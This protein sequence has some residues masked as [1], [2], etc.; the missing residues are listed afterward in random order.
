[1]LLFRLPAFI[2]YPISFM[3]HLYE[4][5]SSFEKQSY[6]EYTKTF[7]EYRKYTHPYDYMDRIVVN[8][9]VSNNSYSIWEVICHF[10]VIDDTISNIHMIDTTDE[11][12]SMIQNKYKKS[13]ISPLM[14]YDMN[15]FTDMYL[16]YIERSSNRFMDWYSYR[17]DTSDIIILN[18]LHNTHETILTNIFISIILQKPTGSLILEMND[19]ASIFSIDLLYIIGSLYEDVFMVKPEI[20]DI[21]QNEIFIFCYGMREFS[22]MKFIS[23]M[24][25]LLRRSYNN[26]SRIISNHIPHKMVSSILNVSYINKN[27]QS[28]SIIDTL[29]IQNSIS[30][31]NLDIIEKKHM[32][33]CKRWCKRYDIEY[34]E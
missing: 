3:Y 11:L 21:H 9:K 12:Q 18:T 24:L 14:E 29:K 19:I 23:N 27:I 4:R 17:V 22:K 26:D 20:S 7:K 15:T 25:P 30:S 5:E 10:D 16:E 2:P 34:K 13:V 6:R 31:L 33:K 32:S 28:N 1:M 8:T